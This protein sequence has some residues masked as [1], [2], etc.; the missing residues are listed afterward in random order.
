MPW[1]QIFLP[2][3]A[4]VASS[5]PSASLC[6]CVSGGEKS[7][8]MIFQGMASLLKWKMAFKTRAEPAVLPLEKK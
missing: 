2:W 8:A 4:A 5:T 7:S 3:V 1:P 6:K